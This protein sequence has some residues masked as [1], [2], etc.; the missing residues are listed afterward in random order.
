MPFR[1]LGPAIGQSFEIHEGATLIVGRAGT[2]D[3]PVIDPTVSRRH[4]ELACEGGTVLVRDLDSSNGT[5]VNG[6]RV[7]EARL[8]VG[9]VVVF[10][11]VPFRLAAVGRAGTTSVSDPGSA[12]AT[13]TEG[14][15]ILRE[16]GVDRSAG[17]LSTIVHDTTLAEAQAISRGSQATARTERK[18]ALLLEVSKGLSRAANVQALL[19]TMAGMAFQILDVD[20]VVIELV[21]ERGGRVPRVSRDRSGAPV[22]HA[23]PRSIASKVA[24]D[25]VA[26][27][28]GN[29]PDDA[30][31]GGSSILAQ[32]VRSAMCTPLIGGSNRV[33]GI[34]YVDNLTTPYSFGD[35]DLDF[36]VAFSSIAAV[37][38]ENS[39]FAERSRREAL[40][41]S[42]FERFFTP[43]LAAR[44][45]ASPGAVQLGGEKRPIAVLFSDIRGFTAIAE[46]MRPDAVAN[47]LSEYFTTMVEIVFRHGGTLDK[48][49][50]DAM[51]AQWGAPV[52]AADDPDRAMRAALEMH[53]ELEV[54][55]ARW[56]TEGRPRLEIGIGL[57][58]GES[59]AG[60]IGS[61]H[62]LE[63]TVIGDAVNIASRLCSVAEGGEILL[64]EDLRGAL[65]SMPELRERGTLELRGKRTPVPVYSVV[66]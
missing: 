43:A 55:N 32:R 59:F 31:F 48:F 64:T 45:A 30:R 27:L 56:F 6:V 29:A 65:G 16:R 58:Y 35:D 4:A 34:L 57:N 15:A 50:G 47:L 39:R 62:R 3:L 23:V 1:L 21:D 36:L 2:C 20:R 7:S 61:E 46:G 49:I 37:A 11:S 51:M 63:Y 54:L 19:D 28:S 60:Y 12:A 17:P 53:H 9:D 22:E 10:G 38:I 18:L 66:R 52:G 14:T 42:N 40:V 8:S 24:R 41:R 13:P 5:L 25:R 33:E 44:I 26:I